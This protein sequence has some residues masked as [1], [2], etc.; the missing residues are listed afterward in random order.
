YPVPQKF[1][2]CCEYCL[3]Q[4][5]Q[6]VLRST[7]LRAISYSL[8]NAWNSSPGPDPQNSD[9][10]RYFLPRL[11]EFVAQ[12]QFDNIHEVFSLRRINLA[13]KENWREDEWKILQRF[14]CQYMT[15]WVSGDEAV[16]LQYMLEMFFRADIALAPLLDAINSVPGFWSTVSLACL[17]NRYCEDYIRDNQDDIDNV[18]TTQINAWAF[19]NQSILKERARQAIENPPKQP[20]QGT[21]HQVWVDDWIIDE[22]LC[23]M[24]DASSES[25]GK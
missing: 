15:D 14:A 25:P 10:V 19:N 12:G 22:C 13:S 2:V 8:I 11:L 17:L 7:S 18:I 16:E 20:E 9:E 1:V 4:Q 24:Y 23:A 21:Q 6:K 3:S 5:E